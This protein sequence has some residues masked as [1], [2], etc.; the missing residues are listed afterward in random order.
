MTEDTEKEQVKEETENTEVVKEEQALQE[1]AQGQEQSEESPEEINWR[2]F[3][4]ERKRDREEKQEEARRR[5]E[6]ERKADEMK[7][8]V[9]AI[10]GNQSTAMTSSEKKELI[11]ELNLEDFNTGKQVQ[12]YIDARLRKKDED[13]EAK[14]QAALRQEREKLDKERKK[15]ELEQLPSRV[16]ADIADYDKVCN[17]D[18]FDYLEYHHP[19]IAKLYAQQ[20]DSYE[21]WVGL[22]KTMKKLIP[23]TSIQSDTRRMEENSNKPRSASTPGLTQTGDSTPYSLSAERKAQNWERMQR[24]MR[25]G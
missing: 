18:S 20:P 16:R 15:Q 1:G 22:Y 14:V 2:K 17:T 7:Q 8:I 23:N 13:I 21:K 12:D 9:E 3:R 24:Q 5:Q 4:A 10:S 25:G 11:A 19:E 6:A